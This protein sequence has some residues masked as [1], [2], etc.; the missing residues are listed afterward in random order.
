MKIHTLFRL[1][2]LEY[3]KKYIRDSFKVNVNINL[4]MNNRSIV[5]DGT[6]GEVNCLKITLKK[7]FL[8]NCF[9]IYEL[10]YF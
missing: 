7:V 6:N 10:K 3:S 4:L 2:F 5:T 1:W 9:E 8:K